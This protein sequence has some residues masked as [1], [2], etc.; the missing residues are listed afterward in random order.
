[1]RWRAP[2]GSSAGTAQ[3]AGGGDVEE[4]SPHDAED[5]DGVFAAMERRHQAMTQRLRAQT[6]AAE[7]ALEAQMAS[8]DSDLAAE[9]AAMDAAAR[10]EEPSLEVMGMS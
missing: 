4:Q 10:A 6:T 5:I 9:L 1:M 3:S 2:G 7:P 8:G